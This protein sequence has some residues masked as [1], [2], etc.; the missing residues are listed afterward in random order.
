VTAIVRA[1]T[2][3]LAPVLVEQTDDFVRAGRECGRARLAEVDDGKVVDADERRLPPIAIDTT[4]K[5]L[6]RAV[7]TAIGGDSCARRVIS[8]LEG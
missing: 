3:V 7:G 1:R 8:E 2:V 5:V 4:V 6:L